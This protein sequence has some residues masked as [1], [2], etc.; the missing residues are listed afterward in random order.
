VSSRAYRARTARKQERKLETERQ[1]VWE[2]LKASMMLA[3][4]L[5]AELLSQ[6]SD[7]GSTNGRD[8][9]GD[10][11]VDM[12]APPTVEER[13][14]AEEAELLR[15]ALLARDCGVW[16][17]FELDDEG[18]EVGLSCM[19]Q[20]DDYEVARLLARERPPISEKEYRDTVQRHSAPKRSDSLSST[21]RA[22]DTSSGEYAKAGASEA[23]AVIS[24]SSSS[25]SLPSPLTLR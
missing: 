21:D 25:P 7:G 8:D 15:L 14:D 20:D 19:W 18:T 3:E 5:F 16:L 6:Q 4:D 17:D 13:F 24:D 9:D 22:S 12:E 1:E 11:D 23:S 2:Y 10:S